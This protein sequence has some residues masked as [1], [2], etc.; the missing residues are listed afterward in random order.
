MLRR[1]TIDLADTLSALYILSA[2]P[3][4]GIV[5]SEHVLILP[6]VR[7]SEPDRGVATLRFAGARAW[8]LAP[9]FGA[10]A[11]ISGT[12]VVALWPWQGFPP[13]AAFT[14]A[15][16]VLFLAA[17]AVTFAVYYP[18]DA[19]FRTL[20]PVTAPTDGPRTINQLIRRNLVRLSLYAGGFALFAVGVVLT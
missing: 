14:V 10:T 17:V 7:S 9:T 15:G 16:V 13:A 20:S 19:R 6:L 4:A 2:G 5:L 8:K 12:A 1:M 3:L 11:G 18:V